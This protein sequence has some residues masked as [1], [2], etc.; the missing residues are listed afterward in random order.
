MTIDIITDAS[1]IM[2]WW[3][4]IM[5]TMLCLER[6]KKTIDINNNAYKIIVWWTLIMIVN[7]VPRKR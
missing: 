7:V 5:F 6:D 3:T 2:E 4:L 1:M